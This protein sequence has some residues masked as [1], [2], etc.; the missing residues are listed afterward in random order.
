M[1]IL[2]KKLEKINFF[3]RYF[4]ILN[5]LIDKLFSQLCTVFKKGPMYL[6]ADMPCKLIMLSSNVCIIS[7]TAPITKPLSWVPLTYLITSNL[8]LSHVSSTSLTPFSICNSLL[9]DVTIF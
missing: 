8:S 3:K 5:E 7:S 6:E 2:I 4:H 9:A 1:N